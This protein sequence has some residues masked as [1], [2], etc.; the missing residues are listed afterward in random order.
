MYQLYKEVHGDRDFGFVLTEDS[1][2]GFEMAKYAFG[3]DETK[4]LAA[5]G[6]SSIYTMLTKHWLKDGHICLQIVTS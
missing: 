1:N 4:V 3:Y 5:G 6:N 2:S